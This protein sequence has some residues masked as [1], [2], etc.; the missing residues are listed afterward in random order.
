MKNGIR[1]QPS[2]QLS[3]IGIRVLELIGIRVIGIIEIKRLVRVIRFLK[4]QRHL[5]I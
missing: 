3:L 5:V 4:T 1:Q 2:M